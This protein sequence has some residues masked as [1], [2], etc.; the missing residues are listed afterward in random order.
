MI[1]KETT[2]KV[3]ASA[4]F[5]LLHITDT[6]LTLCDERNDK[7]KNELAA[8]RL[9][10]F[11]DAEKCLDEAVEY[12]KKENIRIIH[13]GDLIDFVSEAN[14]D[15]AAEFVKEADPIFVTGNHEFSLYVGEAF[16]DEAYRNISLAHV[17]ESFKEDIR[18]NSMVIN[19]VNLVLI[20]D[21]YYRFEPEQFEAFKKDVE[22]GLP[23]VIFMHN[24]LYCPDLF[25]HASAL[26]GKDAAYLTSIPEELMS[27]YS[28]YRF[29]QHRADEMTL[30]MTRYIE[31]CPLVKAIVTGHL[32]YDF[33][34]TVAGR[35]P[36]IT[37]G[38]CTGR[39]LCF[40]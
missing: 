26:P 39:V 1:L 29:K 5:K 34:S 19:G 4:P 28:E 18:Y 36:Q 23:I 15:R 33:E 11:P 9:N 31:N 32:H 30:E 12:S 38:L 27:G 24:P 8:N 37:T 16:E 7:R 13:T 25:A 20:D 17:Q 22:K 10:W 14:L 35:I 2:L 40:E 6:H 21:G 3:G